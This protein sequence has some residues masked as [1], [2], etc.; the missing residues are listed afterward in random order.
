MK[1]ARLFANRPTRRPREI[2]LDRLE[3]FELRQRARAERRAQ[4]QAKAGKRVRVFQETLFD[5]P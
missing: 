1:Q 4:V 3:G 5:H 2:V